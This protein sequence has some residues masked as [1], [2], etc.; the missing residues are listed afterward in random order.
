MKSYKCF[1][2]SPGDTVEERKICR[3]VVES[4]HNKG[5]SIEVYGWEDVTSNINGNRAQTHINPWLAECDIFIGIM[6]LKFGTPTGKESSGTVEEFKEVYRE[7]QISGGRAPR[8]LFYFKEHKEIPNNQES[9]EHYQKICE[10]RAHLENDQVGLYQSYTDNSGFRSLLERDLLK[11]IDD[12]KGSLLQETNINMSSFFIGRNKDLQNLQ[13]WLSKGHVLVS[14]PSGIG[15]TTLVQHLCHRPKIQEE[16]AIIRWLTLDREQLVKR[17]SAAFR[18]AFISKFEP[19]DMDESDLLCDWTERFKT[20]VKNHYHLASR[21]GRKGLLIIDNLDYISDEDYTC[22]KSLLTNEHGWNILI[23]TRGVTQPNIHAQE[24]ALS[25]LEEEKCVELFRRTYEQ[26]YGLGFDSNAALSLIKQLNHNTN[27]IS[28]VAFHATQANCGSFQEYCENSAYYIQA[29]GLDNFFNAALGTL[30]PE[31]NELLTFMIA[32]TSTPIPRTMLKEL[33]DPHFGDSWGAILTSLLQKQWVKVFEQKITCDSKEKVVIL[34]QCHSLSE[35]YFKGLS[36][37]TTRVLNPI[38]KTMANLVE[39]NFLVHWT[40]VFQWI[41]Y[42]KSLVESIPSFKDYDMDMLVLNYRYLGVS[43]KAGILTRDEEI[44][45]VSSLINQLEQRVKPFPSLSQLYENSTEL[46]QEEVA[47]SQEEAPLLLL[48][49]LYNTLAS[50][51][52]EAQTPSEREEALSI[53]VKNLNIAKKMRSISREHERHYAATLRLLGASYRVKKAYSEAKSLI[54]ES[55]SV[56][57]SLK[58]EENSDYNLTQMYLAASYDALG[59]VYSNE[60]NIE[61]GV[62]YR[63][64]ALDIKQRIVGEESLLFISTLSNCA[65]MYSR[66]ADQ[67]KGGEKEELLDKALNAY[68]KCR[69]I[70]E[71]KLP[72]RHTALV[73]I[74]NGLCS[75][76]RK[77][78]DYVQAKVFN[79]KSEDIAKSA[80]SYPAQRWGTIYKNKALIARDQ[81]FWVEA[82]TN[83]T[84]AIK[85]FSESG[86]Q[87]ELS[88][89]KKIKE[90][91]KMSREE[92]EDHEA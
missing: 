33:L 82:E 90:K 36:K 89:I 26:A 41:P 81:G 57:E 47:S 27:V 64:R 91:I 58:S 92:V 28:I 6:S 74:Y 80:R 61:Q 42:A 5:Y 69:E 62:K 7:N 70:R 84:L 40:E 35:K 4:L 66:L 55:I 79:K 3:S 72:P 8:I 48:S 53:R 73:Y 9:R 71:A 37:I 12:L 22:L 18:R 21:K 1:I 63:E 78:G 31:E 44:E 39:S 30:T 59:F 67:L 75:V 16:Y 46:G 49:R 23:T 60:D 51:Y 11:A 38:V 83:I 13:K 56:L 65:T 43:R 68:E 2:A 20:C 15:K 85:Y 76:Y 77:K 10:F 24:Y 45:Y 52:A 14:A 32:L 54:E 50:I 25:H 88:R 29:N 34:Y 86:N 17:D 19:K 87:V